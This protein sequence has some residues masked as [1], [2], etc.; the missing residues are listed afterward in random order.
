MAN[1]TIRP[2]DGIQS[3]SFNVII[4]FPGGV[5]T[6]FTDANISL[7]D[8]SGNGATN[9]TVVV[10]GMG[11]SYNVFV[12]LPEKVVGKLK[13]EL[14][15]EVMV[16]DSSQPSPIE[17]TPIEI[18]YDTV[19]TVHA[20]FGDLDY[21][22]TGE[23]V[24]PINFTKRIIYFHKTDCRIRKIFG[25]DVFDMEYFLTGPDDA[26]DFQLR[27]SPESDRRGAFSVDIPGYIYDTT[28]RIRD[29][30]VVTPKL[31][32]FNTYKPYMAAADI[33]DSLSAGIWDILIELNVPA[34]H[35]K[36]SDFRLEFDG[37]LPDG[38]EDEIELYHARSLDVEPQ[39]PSAAS[40]VANSIGDWQRWD[41]L[42]DE[43]GTQ[44]QGKYFILRFNVP[45]SI[46]GKILS[47][48]P[49]PVIGRG[50]IPGV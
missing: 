49:K 13:F 42:R 40:G 21:L 20:M 16:E 1:A 29:E 2:L 44:I 6:G 14:T 46:A 43:D 47:I 39:R 30:I 32:P 37:D 18:E 19:S 25:D 35:V 3:G 12:T 8:V 24:L 11:Q 48:T 7:G 36:I 26:D 50:P 41:S 5:V 15:G 27:F 28:R 38:F 23:I 17:S 31:V 33:P 10:S 9:V 45:V 34:I 4:H 22:E